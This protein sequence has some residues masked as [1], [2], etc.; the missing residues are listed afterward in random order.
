[1]R[2]ILWIKKEIAHVFPVFLFF[3]FF[4]ILINWIETY[5]F[6]GSHLRSFRLSEV[7]LA[8]ALIAKIILVAD[9]W[10]LIH[11]FRSYPLAYG[12]L[13]KTALYWVILLLVRLLIRF[14]PFVYGGG[15]HFELDLERFIYH[16]PWNIFLS[17]QAYYLMLLFI[18]ITFQELTYKIGVPKMR[19]LFFGK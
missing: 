17:I 13:W 8:A 1:M 16:V 10:P 15:D 9:H 7:A 11:R 19:H 3:L 5:L 4:F 18:F 6:E 14:A 2:P 12:I